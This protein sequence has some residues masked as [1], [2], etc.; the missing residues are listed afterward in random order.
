MTDRLEVETQILKLEL[1]EEGF[2]LESGELLPAVEVACETYGELD[3]DGSNA[4]CVC[5]TLTSDA[6]AAGY[7]P[8]ADQP[9]WWDPAIGPGKPM[10]TDR[11][12]VVCSNI[13]GGCKGTTG[14]TSV[15]PAS[16]RAYGADFPIITI[17]DAVRVQKL[18]LEQ[19]GVTRL[20]TVIGGSLGGMQALE[21][22]VSFPDFVEQC[23]CIAAGASLSPQALAF[24][25]IARQEIEHD[26]DW[27]DG[28]Y[29][30][31]GKT[32]DRGLSRA[33]QI[34]HV[35][36]LS[37]ASMANKFGRETHAED[38]QVR[39]SKFSTD[40]QV[41]SYL[42]YQ[43]EK[44]VERFDANSYLYITKMMDHFDL[45]AEYGSLRRALA[46]ATCR[47]L[48]VAVTSDWLFPPEQ[49]MEIVEELIAERK[50]VSYFRIDSILGH[51][52]FLLEYETLNPGLD[53][54]INGAIPEI[55]PPDVN[56][57]DIEHIT[58]MLKPQQRLLDIGSGD[59]ATF[60]H[61]ARA[62]GISGICLDYS[63]DMVAACMRN[64]LN[65]VQLDADTALER[66]AD[67]SFDAILLNQ[68]IQQLH[69]A[70]RALKQMIRIAPTAIIGYPNFA[71][72]RIRLQL[73]WRG[74]LPV[75]ASLPY[76]W[77]DTPNVH[78]VTINDFEQ[79]CERNDLQIDKVE[80]LADSGLGE[81]LI[82]LGR[83]NLGAERVLVRITR[84]T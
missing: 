46:R 71:F 24:D 70:L 33:R 28:R 75:T 72:Y 9:G 45:P 60:L 11:Y 44:F 21:W 67:D 1:P 35:T 30:D 51:D 37:S 56:R 5:P 39:D 13:L 69:R 6:H 14:P 17:K 54:F 19:L 52:A 84:N 58:E 26:P 79:L 2:R 83:P 7:H 42:S 3:A 38:G 40:F 49:Q 80:Y 77:Y 18:F 15:N 74:R 66:I 36:Y 34:G 43:G 81:F 32:P 76:E 47:F 73:F 10:D 65:A 4:I 82:K 8:G 22:A 23:V 68:T 12:F 16:G 64:G 53:A 57:H 61:L 62:R 59:G 29:D 41:E 31:A 50:E 63:F 27:R 55:P 20:H 78:V 25:I 48:I